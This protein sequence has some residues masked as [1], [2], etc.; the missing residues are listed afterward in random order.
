MN[1]DNGATIGFK[2]SDD[3]YANHDPSTSNVACLND[4]TS[5]Y[6]SIIYLLSNTS[7]EI[8]L[9]GTVSTTH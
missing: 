5:S 1:W 7:T 3:F 8:P 4:P 9:P 6:S 2:G